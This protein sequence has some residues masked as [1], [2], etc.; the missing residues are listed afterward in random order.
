MYAAPETQHSFFFENRNSTLM[1]YIQHNFVL[2]IKL[3]SKFCG[4]Q[5]CF[6]IKKDNKR[7]EATVKHAKECDLE[8]NCMLKLYRVDG[9]NV[10]LFFNCIHSL[11]GAKFNSYYVPTD[12]FSLAQEV[13]S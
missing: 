9:E 8:G 11:V 2:A 10:E 5:D 7:W 4:L 12:K 6:N 1:H 13:W 3:T